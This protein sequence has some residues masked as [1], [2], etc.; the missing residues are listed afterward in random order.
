MTNKHHEEIL[1]AC[2]NGNPF[3]RQFCVALYEFLHLIDDLV[4]RDVSPPP[5]DE[6]IG[7][8]CVQLILTIGGNPFYQDNRQALEALILRGFG[9][10]LDANELER[11]QKVEGKVLKSWYH[12]LFWHVA[13]ITGGWDRSR[14]ICRKYRAFDMSEEEVPHGLLR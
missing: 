7:K 14:D 9:A 2:A 10:W 11:N 4:D 6:Q 8:L 5:T 12:E 3:A 1:E 13:T